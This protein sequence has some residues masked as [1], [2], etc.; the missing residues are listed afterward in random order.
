MVPGNLPSSGS[1][2]EPGR[3]IQ[4]ALDDLL[5]G[6]GDNG[7]CRGGIYG[8]LICGAFLKR[9]KRPRVMDVLFVARV[10]REH[11]G[12][13]VFAAKVQ[14]GVPGQHGVVHVDD[15]DVQF[16]KNR[17]QVTE[18]RQRQRHHAGHFD[19]GR[20]KAERA[21]RVESGGSFQRF[22]R[23]FPLF[24]FFIIFHMVIRGENI[25][26]MPA[27]TKPF[28]KT[29]H[30]DRHSRHERFVIVGKHCDIHDTHSF[31]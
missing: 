20:G 5:L 28:G 12:N 1:G 13:M 16:G 7:L 6:E 23:V 4:I 24:F 11:D 25:N 18:N 3:I 21:S 15:V 29:L 30:G 8:V 9:T 10:I 31:T 14:G 26:G 19:V 22:H 27:G 2:P 17:I